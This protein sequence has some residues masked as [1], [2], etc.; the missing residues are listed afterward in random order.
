[1]NLLLKNP[2]IINQDIFTQTLE[3]KAFLRFK[4][5]YR[6]GTGLHGTQPKG[7]LHYF[8]ETKDHEG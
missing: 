7:H 8:R 1:M 4:V 5:R 6:T 3:L 2:V